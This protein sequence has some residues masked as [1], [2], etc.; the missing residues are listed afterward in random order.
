[1]QAPFTQL[2]PSTPSHTLLQQIAGLG[3]ASPLWDEQ[4]KNQAWAL[5][6]A[7]RSMQYHDLPDN[8]HLGH[9]LPQFFGRPGLY[10][11]LKHF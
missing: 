7:E 8:Q 6:R 10:C 9:S 1:M 5:H 4:V 3:E 11:E 2:I